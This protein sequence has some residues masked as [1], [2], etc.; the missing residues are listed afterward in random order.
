MKRPFALLGL[1]L[2]LA[3]CS[4]TSDRR[5]PDRPPVQASTISQN[6]E[7]RQCF[8]ALGAAGNSFTPLP[9]RYTGQGCSMLGTV[10]LNA[11]A[12]DLSSAVATNLGPVTCP[13]SNAFAEWARYGVDR[14]AR[15]LLG[16]PLRSIETYGSYACRN[17]ARTARRSAHSTAEAIDVAGFVLEDG[18]RIAVKEDW[19]GGSAQEREFLRVVHQSACRRFDTVLSPDYNADHED[20]LHLEGVIGQ[21]SFC[22]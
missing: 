18:R 17:V 9:D 22:R 20:H 8:A 4:S 3:A 21:R 10:Q 15:V 14:A 19:T 2:A 6:Y 7:V 11:I 12:T 16:S 1:T 5:E 13:V